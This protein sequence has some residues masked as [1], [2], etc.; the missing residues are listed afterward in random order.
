MTL[1]TTA[2]ATLLD[3]LAPAELAEVSARLPADIRR[4]LLRLRP[5]ADVVAWALETGSAEDRLVLAEN[6]GVGRGVLRRLLERAE[7]RVAVAVYVHPEFTAADRR[8]VCEADD[9][10]GAV[11][12]LLLTTRSRK[13]L[14]PALRASD[15][16]VAAHAGRSIGG[17]KK[18]RPEGRP[19]ELYAWMA[20]TPHARI[21]HLRGRM[22]LFRPE[23][24]S[25]ADWR[26]LV[27]LHH[28]HPMADSACRA[29][30]ES[31]VCPKDTAL[32]FLDCRQGRALGHFSRQPTTAMVDT[33]VT[34]LRAGLI[35]AADLLHRAQAAPRILEL[36]M[37]LPRNSGAGEALRT[38]LH[39]HL[40]ENPAR[41]VSL[42]ALLPGFTGTVGALLEAAQEPVMATAE[43]HEDQASFPHLLGLAGPKNARAIVSA[44]GLAD[45]VYPVTAA[46]WAP[47]HVVEA[48]V[49]EI[50][51]ERELLRIAGEAK[52]RPEVYLPLLSR[53]DPDV[54][55]AVL[56]HSSVPGEIARRVVAGV[57]FGPGRRKTLRTTRRLTSHLISGLNKNIETKHLTPYANDAGVLAE[58]VLDV[59]DRLRDSEQLTAAASLVRTGRVDILRDVIANGQIQNVAVSLTVSDALRAADPAA[60]LDARITEARRHE[61]VEGVELN[62]D[63][64]D[65]FL[66]WDWIREALADGRPFSGAALRHLCTRPHC[67]DDVSLAL[68]RADPTRTATW[69]AH[70]SPEHALSA[71]ALL[72]GDQVS[73]ALL[74]DCVKSGAL[75]LT[76][77]FA[78]GCP[79]EAVLRTGHPV[80]ADLVADLVSAT[81]DAWAVVARLLPDFPGTL[82]ELIDTVKAITDLP[83]D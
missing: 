50:T 64:L 25:V 81:A 60:F 30:V 82:R 21:R 70:R 51:D 40:G 73:A 79:A 32:A 20:Q 80:P 19:A 36:I 58:A 59:R 48:V 13:L 7:P 4:D 76:D 44:P 53:D 16:E 10:P 78:L 5:S 35:D 49:D 56:I 37:A 68:L 34:A 3:S 55:A 12:E 67:P 62:A 6:P 61:C 23:D 46:G 54:N 83:A 75:T 31:G 65:D 1:A 17:P 47:G 15:P 11:R 27:E 29:V 33:A 18:K 24:W 8:T 69:L 77:L 57:P 41:W 9:L 63:A 39:E 43:L 28:R 22:A 45:V 52:S 14:A 2:F 26:E 66:E 72:P 71:L 38:Q 74:E 42:F